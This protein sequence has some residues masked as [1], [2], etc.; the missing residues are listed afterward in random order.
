[1]EETIF[2]HGSLSYLED[3]ELLVPGCDCGKGDMHE[4][5]YIT[6]H[7]GLAAQF[8]TYDGWVYMVEP[9]GDIT[10]DFVDDDGKIIS[11]ICASAKVLA[12]VW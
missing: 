4:D 1:M 6:P 8:A 3:G 7:I 9:I 5:V 11:Y 12:T 10:P 2:Y